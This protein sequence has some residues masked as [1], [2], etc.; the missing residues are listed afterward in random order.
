MKNAKGKAGRKHRWVTDFSSVYAHCDNCGMK[1]RNGLLLPPCEG[2]R[3]AST[4]P[5]QGAA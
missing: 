4:P 1:K 3:R 5:R 2:K